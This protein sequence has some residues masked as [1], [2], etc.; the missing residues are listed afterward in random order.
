M[1]NQKNLGNK[2]KTLREDKQIS[3]EELAEKVGVGRAAISQIENGGRGIGFLELARI[4]DFFGVRTDY[5]LIE[6]SLPELNNINLSKNNFDQVKLRNVLLYILEKCA[7][8]PNIGETVLYKLLYF[9][10]FD[11]FEIYKKAIIG[12]DYV[13]LQFGPVPVSSQYSSVITKMK[14]SEELRVISQNYYGLKIK[15]YINL[16]SYPLGSLEPEETK[17]IDFVIN[18]F[19]DLSATKIEDYVHG[20]APWALTKKGDL[21]PYHLVFEREAPYSKLEN[22]L[23]KFKLTGVKDILK[24]VGDISKEDYDY[25]ERL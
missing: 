14:E 15:R 6:E 9:V 1:I 17:V 22:D 11:S 7:G 23:R 2:I 4:A 21:I 3:Q 25:Y 24:E 18:S 19:S 5:F 8:K 13:N 16:V 10:D 12:L 20:D